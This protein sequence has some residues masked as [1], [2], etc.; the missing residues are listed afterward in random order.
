MA[1]DWQGVGTDRRGRVDLR[2]VRWW[3]VDGYAARVDRREARS[4]SRDPRPRRP[5][6][7]MQ[8]GH[9]K[10]AAADFWRSRGIGSAWEWIGEGLA[11]IGY[12][13][14]DGSA[15][16]EDE[17]IFGVRS[18]IRRRRRRPFSKEVDLALTEAACCV[19]IGLLGGGEFSAGGGV[20][21]WAVV[22][23]A[24]GHFWCGGCCWLFLESGCIAGGR[25]ELRRAEAK[26]ARGSRSGPRRAEANTARRAEAKTARRA[27]A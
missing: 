26:S 25:S 5:N 1:R 21:F 16:G 19:A 17:W 20:G 10:V 13:A 22:L 12:V 15:R 4:A 14:R 9:D 23:F 18:W 11:V 7:W 24:A 3:G 6:L 8:L 27:E 2:R